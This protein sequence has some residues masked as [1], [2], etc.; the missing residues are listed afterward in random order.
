MERHL[1]QEYC[2]QNAF[3]RGRSFGYRPHGLGAHM[4]RSTGLFIAAFFIGAAFLICAHIL[5]VWQMTSCW[6]GGTLV[7][8]SASAK[9]H[10]EV[11]FFAAPNWSL[12][13]VLLF[14]AF[15]YCAAETYNNARHSVS[16][17][18]QRGMIVNE[19]W[20]PVPEA[21]VAK[22]F[23]GQR[24]WWLVLVVVVLALGGV[25]LGD[26]FLD[27]VRTPYI[28]P[29]SISSISLSD[30]VLEI[31]WSVAAPSC[32]FV[33]A[34]ICRQNQFG[35]SGNLYF[36]AAAYVYLTWIG[37]AL[38]L[39]FV[40]AVLIFA[41]LFLSADFRARRMLLVPDLTS[42]DDRRGF[43]LL[44]GFFTSAIAGVFMLFALGYLV[45]LQN[46][47]LRTDYSNVLLLIF[48]FV[49]PGGGL[50]LDGMFT[51][52]ANALNGQL[53]VINPNIVAV[54]VIGLLILFSM[55]LSVAFAL[56]FTARR[57]LNALMNALQST[58]GENKKLVDA[59][60]KRKGVARKAALSALENFAFWPVR[61]LQINRLFI[62]LAAATL[63]L[64]LVT[65]GFYIIAAGLGA[66]LGAAYRQFGKVLV[67]DNP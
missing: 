5:G 52:I 19:R 43:E 23:S 59:Y 39:G 44:E 22:I 66:I 32:A 45:T 12:G 21:D 34:P 16:E 15:I 42:T 29:D 31:D 20:E 37:A 27:V 60:L 61:W 14:P 35:D 40:V 67:G 53:S 50:S 11:G 4:L 33:E 1:D 30:P 25:F 7:A 10:K 51:G 58:S 8:C 48:P 65:L 56:R 36:A 55:L 38:A 57:G 6:T 17:M 41:T 26:D 49:Q 63:A 9:L 13:L 47:Y 46:T 2:V 54:T 28:N 24:F 3:A 18:C 62:W 64:L